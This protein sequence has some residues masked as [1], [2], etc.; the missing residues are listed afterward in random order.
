[1][2]K[3]KLI[4]LD[5]FSWV[6]GKEDEKSWE[7]KNYIITVFGLFLG[8]W[9]GLLYIYYFNRKIDSFKVQQRHRELMNALSR[10]T[11]IIN[12]KTVSSGVN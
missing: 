3:L 7:R 4:F 11:D 2:K 5:F 8:I 12:N 1:M 10:I 6:K 9:P